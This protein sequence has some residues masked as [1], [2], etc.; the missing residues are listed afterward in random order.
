MGAKIARIEPR[1]RNQESESHSG[2]NA[3]YLGA[4][5]FHADLTSYV[6]HGAPSSVTRQ[7]TKGA[8]MNGGTGVFQGKFPVTRTVGQ[9]T[10]AD[11]QHQ[12]LLL[13]EGAAVFAKPE[14][15]IYA[16][17]VRCSHGSKTGQLDEYAV[18][19]L[20]AR[21]LDE[22]GATALLLTAFASDVLNGI[23]NEELRTSL[24]AKIQDKLK[25]MRAGANC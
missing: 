7:L 12:A 8:V 15:E 1:V 23:S 11:M 13:E 14:L 18:F 19:Y 3:A 5:G 10:D 20:R 6:S 22:F 25:E 9:Y 24:E 21:V 2:M 4:N 16:D 17:D